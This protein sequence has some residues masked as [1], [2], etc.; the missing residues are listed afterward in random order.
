MTPR[1]LAIVGP[2]A[3]G[4]TQIAIEVARRV[5]GEVISLDSMQAYQGMDIGTATPDA[6]E[7]GD[8]PHHM[9]D[10]WPIGHALT[11]VEFR[12][13]ARAAIEDV[14]SRGRLPIAVGGSGLYVRAVL[15]TL[16][17]P[18]TDPD[19]RA[20]LEERLADEGSVALHAE[21]RRID[22]TA[23]ETIAPTNGRRIVRALEVNSITGK[24]FNARL[25]SHEDRYVTTRVGIAIDRPSLDARIQERVDQM[26]R[27]GFVEEVRQLRDVGLAE[28]PTARAALG[29][30]PVLAYLAGEMSEGEARDRTVADTRRFA[31]R[32]QRWFAGDVRTYWVEF[33]DPSLVDEVSDWATRT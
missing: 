3:S 23:A 15:E 8:V 28:A 7:R 32:Q 10:V 19:V 12:D 13:A 17:P 31:R 6:E 26:W 9:F 27:R 24:P 5:N 4:K 22:P 33:N 11:I 1:V 18:G 2:T 30:G 20:V 25:P 16:E 14:W 29:Y 21:L